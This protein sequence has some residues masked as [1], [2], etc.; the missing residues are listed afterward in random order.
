MTPVGLDLVLGPHQQSPPQ[1][2]LP[3]LPDPARFDI[4]RKR[5]A[6]GPRSSIRAVSVRGL[7]GYRLGAAIARTLAP[8]EGFDGRDLHGQ[9]WLGQV[10]HVSRRQDLLATGRLG[11]RRKQR[12]GDAQR[13]ALSGTLSVTRARETAVAC[14]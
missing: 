4:A 2:S 9:R 8:F 10:D 5:C 13:A 1:L 6:A 7:S 12:R 11:A 3:P 14:R